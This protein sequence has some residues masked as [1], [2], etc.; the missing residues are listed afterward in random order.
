MHH[1]KSFTRVKSTQNEKVCFIIANELKLTQVE[2]LSFFFK[3][4]IVFSLVQKSYNLYF[5][6]QAQIYV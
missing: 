3:E 6:L 5:I 1:I 2:L 4:C